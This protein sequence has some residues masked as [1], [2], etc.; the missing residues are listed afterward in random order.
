MTTISEDTKQILDHIKNVIMDSGHQDKEKIYSFLEKELTTK[1]QD[2][3]GNIVKKE[4]SKKDSVKKDS[5]KKGSVKKD[6]DKKDKDPNDYSKYKIDELK[7]LLRQ[8][9][10]KL[11]GK[12]QE[13]IDR[14]KEYM[15]NN[16]ENV[17][18][19]STHDNKRIKFTNLSEE[20]GHKIMYKGFDIFSSYYSNIND[21]KKSKDDIEIALYYCYNDVFIA[22]FKNDEGEQYLLEFKINGPDKYEIL[23]NSSEELSELYNKSE[24]ELIH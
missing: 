13:L 7:S 21:L 6:S 18:Y 1:I 11:T 19:F 15:S 22:I 14:I 5:V 23:K 4:S 2:V 10:L 24:Y 3:F 8:R 17:E 20:W 16:I 12:K 9:N